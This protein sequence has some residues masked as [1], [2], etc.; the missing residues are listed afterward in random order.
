MY[1][2]KELYKIIKEKTVTFRAEYNYDPS[3]IITIRTRE[4]N[5]HYEA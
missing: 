2:P 3:C 4:G 5:S 1:S